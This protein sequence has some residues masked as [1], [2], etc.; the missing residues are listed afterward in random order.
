MRVVS[1]FRGGVVG[2]LVDGL[3][4]LLGIAEGMAVVGLAVVGVDVAG[5]LLGLTVVG[6]DVVDPVMQI[7]G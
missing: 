2:V 5:A 1:N 6:V 7:S 4:D 3:V